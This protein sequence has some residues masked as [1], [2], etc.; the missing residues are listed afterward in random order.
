MALP[1]IQKL[2]NK[3]HKNIEYELGELTKTVAAHPD[4][5]D[6]YITTDKMNIES[7]SLL[8]HKILRTSERL[9]EQIDIIANTKP[10]K[11][12]PLP[13]ELG[14]SPASTGEVNPVRKR[15][16]KTKARS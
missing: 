8:H 3:I 14:T 7:G 12:L 4:Y 5:F 16:R 11:K 13:N 15:S 9:L 10:K 1:S 2:L 6:E